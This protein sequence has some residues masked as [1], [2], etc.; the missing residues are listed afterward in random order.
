MWKCFMW[1]RC[2]SGYSVG[3]TE[4]CYLIH[5]DIFILMRDVTIY[6]VKTLYFR[7]VMFFRRWYV[8]GFFTALN[9]LRRVLRSLERKMALRANL[10]FLFKPLYQEYNIVGYVM[11]FLYRSVK[12]VV[13]A[14][15]YG[16]II[17]CAAVLFVA[18]ACIPAYGIYRIITG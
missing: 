12:L 8:N 16:I 6:L 5:Y 1:D 18:W 4:G 10:H 14:V 7:V 15:V 17:V 9:M 2:C 3:S 13:G 11:G